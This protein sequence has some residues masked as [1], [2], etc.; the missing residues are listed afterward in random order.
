[1]LEETLLEWRDE[2]RKEGLRE[3]EIK[4]R[5]QFLLEQLEQ[6]F[7]VLSPKVRRKV[8]ASSEKRASG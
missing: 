1:M 2:A 7:G 6:R 8:K 3:G 5:R 4:G